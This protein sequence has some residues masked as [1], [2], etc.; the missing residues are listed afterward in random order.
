[1]SRA[2]IAQGDDWEGLYIDGAL[3]DEGHSLGVRN[4]LRFL[5]SAEPSISDADLSVRE[6]DLDWIADRG[7]LPTYIDEVKWA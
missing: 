3:V 5:L 1:M 7:S 4:T 2:V 6:V